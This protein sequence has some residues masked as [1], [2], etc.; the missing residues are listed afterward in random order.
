VEASLIRTIEEQ[1]PGLSAAEARV[2]AVILADPD[3]AVGSSIATIARRAQ[4]S[5]P[6]VL[7]FCRAVG[8]TGFRDFKVKLAQSRVARPWFVHKGI[9]ETDAAGVYAHKVLDSTLD[10]IVRIRG[11]LSEVAIERAVDALAHA[12]DAGRIV[13][14]GLG[15]SGA[16]AHDAAC[17]F[18]F[19]VTQCHAYADGHMQH[20]CAPTLG[21]NDVLVAISG[22]GKTRDLVRNARLARRAGATVVAITSPDSPLAEVAS[23]VVAADVRENTDVYT[24]SISRIVHLLVV[25][26]LAVGVALR[27]SRRTE[28]RVERI[29]RVVRASRLQGGETLAHDA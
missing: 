14:F 5:Q 3:D 28:A 11:S 2:A 6:T 23:V 27:F 10:T 26:I 21:P 24:P 17:K 22:T 19:L 9:D 15:A 1:V 16:V 20:M 18:F 29:K 7:R 25:D 13:F 8:C 4:V 12:V